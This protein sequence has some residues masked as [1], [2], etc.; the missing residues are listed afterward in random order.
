MHIP[1]E[2]FEIFHRNR[3]RFVTALHAAVL[4]ECPFD[5][6]PEIF[7]IFGDD[8]LKF[9]EIFSGRT[10]AVPSVRDLVTKLKQVSVYTAMGSCEGDKE[11]IERVVEQVATRLGMR[12]TE[13]R[14]TYINMK[15]LM[16]SLAMELR[17]R[18]DG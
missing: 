15:S 14:Q 9:V 6:L 8:A 2:V 10:V 1:N 12:K 7:D 3:E 18:S 13:V 17:P 16:D 11:K 4:L 5:A